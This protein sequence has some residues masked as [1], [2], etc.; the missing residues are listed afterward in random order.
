M[1]TFFL[2]LTFAGSAFAV[3]LFPP[4]NLGLVGYWPMEEGM[5]SLI[6]DQSG[7]VCLDGYYLCVV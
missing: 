6:Y 2:G 3:I 4:N 5:D 1:L 7:Y